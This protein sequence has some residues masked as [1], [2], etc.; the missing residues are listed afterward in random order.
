MRNIRIGKNVIE[1]LTQGMYEDARFVFREY[2]Q[3]AADQIDKAVESKILNKRSDGTINI[4][5]EPSYKRITI[6]DNATGIKS[7]CILNNLGNIALSEKDRKKDKGFRGIGRLGGLGYCSKLIFITSYKNEDRK[8]I[9]TWDAKMLNN[10][11]NDP[12]QRI[13][14]QSL[15]ELIINIES[16]DEEKDSHYFKVILEDVNNDK[17]L[18]TKNIREYLSMVAPVPFPNHFIFK[19]KIREMLR[20]EDLMI[21]EYNIFLNTDLI[22]KNYTTT[23]YEKSG[24]LRRPVDEIFEIEDFK[25][26]YDN[27]LIA[28]GWYGISKFEKQIPNINIARGIRLRKGNIQIGSE[29]TLIKLHKEQRG[30][31]YF[32]GEIHA[33]HENLIPNS[34]RDYFNE[35]TMLKYF[36]RYLRELFYSKMYKLYYH[37]NKVKN[38]FKSVN[39]PI[40]IKKDYDEKYKAGFTSKEEEKA[41][42]N[43]LDNAIKESQKKNKI[44]TKIEKDSEEDPIFKKVFN[45]I[46]GKY[47]D[48]EKVNEVIRN[49][50]RNKINYR[51]NKLSKLSKKERK[52]LSKIFI[53]IDKVLPVDSAENLKRKIEEEFK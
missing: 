46:K 37:A 27:E 42:N 9:M 15:I 4:L 39:K 36:E 50:I 24:K 34:R 48:T 1:T 28:W 22:T 40:E 10:I 20:K 19:N 43:K 18:D 6:E 33:F 14:A 45:K 23:I 21:D 25:I 52:L 5:I 8:T 7:D 32:I 44:L 38:T 13:D 11:I 49:H 16:I 17:L 35:N 29:N 30:N 41:I 53:V 51:T 26:N 47:N 12:K 2:I 3:N 31:F